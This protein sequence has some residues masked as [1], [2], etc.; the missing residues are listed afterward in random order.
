MRM[1]H[2]LIISS[3][4]SFIHDLNHDNDFIEIPT[5]FNLGIGRSFSALEFIAA[6]KLKSWTRR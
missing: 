4:I 6:S 3:E 2:G 1:S 5:T